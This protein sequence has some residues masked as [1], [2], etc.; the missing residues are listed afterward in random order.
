MTEDKSLIEE[1]VDR[2]K[3]ERDE[4]AVQI[5]LGKKEAQ[6]EWESVQE[7]LSKLLADYEPVKDAVEESA[8]SVFASLKLVA[9]EIG[10]SFHRIKA[11]LPP[12]KKSNRWSRSWRGANPVI[13]Q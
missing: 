11:R 3:Q 7:K 9:G 10:E 5:H 4:L 1:M 13:G 2:L 12:K 6:D 8:S